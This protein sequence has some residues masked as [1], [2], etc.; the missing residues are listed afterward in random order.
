MEQRTESEDSGRAPGVR[1]KIHHRVAPE[2][3]DTATHAHPPPPPRPRFIIPRVPKLKMLNKMRPHEEEVTKCQTKAFLSGLGIVIITMGIGL[4]W[5]GDHSSLRDFLI[6]GPGLLVIGF[7]LLVFALILIIKDIYILNSYEEFDDEK[8]EED[9]EGYV[10]DVRRINSQ[11]ITMAQNQRMDV[12]TVA[13]PTPDA[14]GDGVVTPSDMALETATPDPTRPPDPVVASHHSNTESPVRSVKHPTASSSSAESNTI[15]VKSKEDT[16]L[17]GTHTERF[18]MATGSDPDLDPSSRPSSSS[19]Q[20]YSVS[21]KAGPEADDA[22]AGPR[23]RP[24]E[25]DGAAPVRTDSPVH[26][27]PTV[28]FAED[29]EL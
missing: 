16:P 26:S 6:M 7:T 17:V 3:K 5:F 18:T 25:P 22:R 20:T 15:T 19:L 11:E 12:Y 29:T 14:A 21:M 23:L 13:S 28:S 8:A 24:V 27:K 1:R 9:A 2:A 4:T 10:Y